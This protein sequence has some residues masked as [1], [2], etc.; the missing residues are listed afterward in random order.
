ML[1]NFATAWSPLLTLNIGTR[2]AELDFVH[3]TAI[4]FANVFY[5]FQYF[6]LGIWVWELAE[7]DILLI[8]GVLVGASAAVFR[9]VFTSASWSNK[10]L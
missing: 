7:P 4:F 3:A 2:R 5:A 9:A 6:V 8:V 1:A 10:H